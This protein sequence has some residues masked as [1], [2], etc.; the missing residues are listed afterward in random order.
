MTLVYFGR[1]GRIAG[2]R[3]PTSQNENVLSDTNI[4]TS[5]QKT[6]AEDGVLLTRYIEF[7]E[8][9]VFDEIPVLCNDC[10]M[11]GV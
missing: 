5:F 3:S 6:A 7:S 11:F 8:V 1:D 4:L 10:S 2:V 9:D